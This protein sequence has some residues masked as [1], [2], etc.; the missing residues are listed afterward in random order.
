MLRRTGFIAKLL[1]LAVAVSNTQVPASAQK[2]RSGQDRYPKVLSALEDN[3][4]NFL[5]LS[6]QS[7]SALQAPRI[8]YLPSSD[9]KTV[10]VADFNGVL[11]T[12]EAQLIRS[13]NPQIQSIRIG[14]FQSN[15]PVFRIALT[16]KSAEALKEL[17]FR[18]QPKSLV[19]KLPQKRSSQLTYVGYSPVPKIQA[20]SEAPIKEPTTPRRVSQATINASK[21]SVANPPFKTG[22]LYL[23]LG[24][25]PNKAAE[26]AIAFSAEAQSKSD[27][28]T[29]SKIAM[30]KGRQAMPTAPQAAPSFNS[31]SSRE[32]MPPKAPE[33]KQEE[34]LEEKK[35]TG[36]F[37][38]RLHRLFHSKAAK[39][40]IAPKE[41]LLD[42]E[43]KKES[44]QPKQVELNKS[45]AL[46]ELNKKEIAKEKAEKNTAQSSPSL[47]LIE[48]KKAAASP[49]KDEM[50]AGEEQGSVNP[51]ISISGKDPLS[52]TLKFNSAVKYKSFRLDDPPRYVLDLEDLQGRYSPI[53]EPESNPFLKALRIGNPDEHTTR[54]VLDL[55]QPTALVKEEYSEE[56]KSI[57]LS[58]SKLP[59]TISRSARGRTVVLDAGHGGSDPGAQRGDIQEKQVTLAITQ[60]L[61]R[62][63][64][65]RGLRVIMTRSDD[66]F[67]SLEDRSRITNETHPDAFVSVHINSLETDRD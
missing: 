14:Q 30:L 58:I 29:E 42:A 43:S 64:E 8:S 50:A 65:Q 41:N 53:L 23:E 21:L 4:G 40:E 1:L 19:I 3:D 32:E 63:L 28:R 12:R 7:K 13:S 18:C 9:S 51:E 6:I 48:S 62:D 38:G 16:S 31:S 33:F 25:E 47:A 56:H 37:V 34:A 5:L 54:I 67:V 10:M 46:A 2:L 39:E 20:R 44:V 17:E 60:K 26:A 15:P 11:W 66:T 24:T 22:G 27:L 49:A 57:L 45:P 35:T 55:N 52:L 59:S 61:K 36:G